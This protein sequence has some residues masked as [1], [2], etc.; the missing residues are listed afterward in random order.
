[1]PTALCASR[2]L[3]M[4]CVVVVI[5][6]AFYGSR[7]F[8]CNRR[9]NVSHFCGCGGC[10]GGGR[11]GSHSDVGEVGSVPLVHFGVLCRY[12]VSSIHCCR[13]LF[14]WS[15]GDVSLENNKNS[16]SKDDDYTHNYL[17]LLAFSL[18]KSIFA[19]VR[20]ESH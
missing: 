19:K 2:L 9:N 10:V 1:M 7:E 3:G 6:I 4:S 13:L 5:I 14:L 18:C 11:S 17:Q 12:W 20:N 8:T 16:N 15:G